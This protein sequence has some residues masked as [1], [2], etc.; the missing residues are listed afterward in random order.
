MTGN[1][2]RFSSDSYP[3]TEEGR[4]E[5]LREL[6]C[7]A[8]LSGGIDLISIGGFS[9][10]KIFTNIT[11][12]PQPCCR[13]V[14]NC[15]VIYQNETKKLNKENGKCIVNT[16]VEYRKT[17]LHNDRLNDRTPKD[18]AKLSHKTS[19]CRRPTRDAPKC[20]FS[21]PLFVD[22]DGFLLKIGTGNRFHQFHVRAEVNRVCQVPTSLLSE[23]Q[24]EELRD[25]E[26]S[27]IGKSVAR[28][29][30]FARHGI[31]LST[32]QIRHIARKDDMDL[33]SGDIDEILK[34]FFEK[35]NA[36]CCFLFEKKQQQSP[37][38]VRTANTQDKM[39][40]SG[41]I[42]EI[43]DHDGGK[44]DISE[45][46]TNMDLLEQEAEDMAKY[47]EGVRCARRVDDS[48][49]LL[50]A[51][52][53]VLPEEHR[54]FSLY[55]FVAHIDGTNSTNKE[56]RPLVTVTGRDA[57]GHQFT[58]L[59]AFL[60]NNQAWVFKWLFQTVFP[61]LLGMDALARIAVFITDGDS[62]ETSQLDN[63]IL[64]LC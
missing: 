14:C 34:R 1:V 10:K 37:A 22:N 17:T 39:S 42:S 5:L 54:Q 19:T 20:P 4:K 7:V 32:E 6:R 30:F 36:R 28:N 64:R 24:R 12:E 23:Q 26:R 48:Q 31:L 46:S 15:G 62:Q 13:V 43:H 11:T 25:V 53:W 47:A 63:A 33:E 52:A 51:F 56:S 3:P 29:M 57:L 16:S 21:L 35:E 9:L 8:K 27:H 60:P 50:L 44:Q 59:R 45:A 61:T 58:V 55:P 49:D 41:F 40:G 2:F 38:M 18:D